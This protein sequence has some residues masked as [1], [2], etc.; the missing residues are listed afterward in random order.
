MLYKIN[1][2][3][4]I[5]TCM[6]TSPLHTYVCVCKHLCRIGLHVIH[7]CI[8][9]TI[10]WILLYIYVHV[11]IMYITICIMIVHSPA[12]RDHKEPPD[13]KEILELRYTDTTH[14]YSD[15]YT[16]VCIMYKCIINNHI[17]YRDLLVLMEKLAELEQ[18]ALKEPVA[19][20]D[21]KVCVD[22]QEIKDPK[23]HEAQ[24]DQPALKETK[25]V[26]RCAH[27]QKSFLTAQCHAYIMYV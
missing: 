4:H 15:K 13:H 5:Y 17:W 6:H 19:P 20:R 3:T 1:T 7:I 11:F 22:P 8:H 24:L 27:A 21:T 23:E 25:Y 2:H 10:L 18:L 9:C 14:A 26:H 12:T 16:F